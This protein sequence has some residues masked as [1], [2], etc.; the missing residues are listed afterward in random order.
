M[1]NAVCMLKLGWG[2][3]TKSEALWVR[4]LRF[5]YGC[6]SLAVPKVKCGSKVS[7][8]WRGFCQQW[9]L[10]EQSLLWI[11]KNGHGVWFWQDSWV[12]EVGPLSDHALVELSDYDWHQSVFAYA[13]NGAWN[14]PLIISVLLAHV[15][16]KIASIHAPLGDAADF[17]IWKHS[18]DGVFSV[19]T[20]YDLLFQMSNDAAPD[21]VFELLWK[22]RTPQHINTFL[23]KVAHQSLMTNLERKKRGIIDSDL[24]PRYKL[25]PES[26][27]HILRDCEGRVELWEK[28]VDPDV[29]HL[30]ASLGID[31]W[32]EFNLK[33]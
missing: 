21:T 1:I 18:A 8:V 15:C 12:P 29:W 6:G 28:I 24:C 33:L 27:M 7:H 32:L 31:R 4:I 16:S 2:I 22:V 9:P 30:F 20:A 26:I 25:Y 23:W 17:P 13:E 19:K 3:L 10:V 14:W 5:K 11:V